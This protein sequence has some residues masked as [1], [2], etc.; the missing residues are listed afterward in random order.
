MTKPRQSLAVGVAAAALVAAAVAAYAFA[1]PDRYEA[2]AALEVSPV[3]AGDQTF[4]GMS[5]LREGQDPVETAAQLVETRPV[6]DAAA[7]RLRINGEEALKRI[8]AIADSRGHV[9][10]VRGSGKNGI[11]A[12]RIA[13][14]FADEL[15]RQR[16]SLFRAEVQRTIE[17]LS[18]Q[19]AGIPASQRNEPT[20]FALAQRLSE[21]RSYRDRRDPTLR[22]AATATA[23][24]DPS[25][26][27]PVPILAIGLPLAL[28]FGAAVTAAHAVATRRPPRAAP[29]PEPEP[30]RID[31]RYRERVAAVTARE[32]SLAR[33]A[34]E[35]ATRERVLADR[36][37]Q[38]R[39]PQ[40]EREPVGAEVE[41]RPRTQPPPVPVVDPA[42]GAFAIAYLDRILRER[43]HELPAE[44]RQELRAYLAV[45]RPYA[46][47]D[48][49]LPRSFDAL[50]ADVFS[51]LLA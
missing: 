28:L 44:R 16:G 3:P 38:A 46:R 13:N 48:G 11:D 23:P 29:T 19:F 32:R 31:E 50:V 9:V 45:L 27:K 18:S 5:V 37:A 26:P 7:I 39:A 20:A 6:A 35:L 43:S 40:R 33:R 30:R 41:R 34:E 22:L 10:R 36:E 21:L 2:E 51:D 25:W 14:A 1:W 12:A 17:E 8:D 42:R 15:I 4:A 24:R 47:D 49:T